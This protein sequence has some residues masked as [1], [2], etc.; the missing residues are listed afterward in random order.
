MV[1]E[2]ADRTRLRTLFRGMVYI[3]RPLYYPTYAPAFKSHRRRR[4]RVVHERERDSPAE[5]KFYE[6]TLDR[7]VTRGVS[8]RVSIRMV[9]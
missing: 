2:D 3:D 5:L 8:L 4:R 6:F 7:G 9:E 1:R